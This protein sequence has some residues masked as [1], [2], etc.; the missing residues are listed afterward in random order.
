MNLIFIIGMVKE[1]CT[2]PPNPLPFQIPTLIIS[3]GLD[4]VQ[5]NSL[6]P[7]CKIVK[8]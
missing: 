3:T 1:F 4:H 8:I 5:F 7:A 2:L 6:M